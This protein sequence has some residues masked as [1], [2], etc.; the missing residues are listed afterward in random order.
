MMQALFKGGSVDVVVKT[1]Y[2][3]VRGEALDGVASFKGIPY[4]APPIGARRFLAPARPMAWSGVR[5]ALAFGPTAPH[6]TYP[7]QLTHLL[8]EPILPGDD[9][10]TLNVWTPEPRGAGLPV[11]VWIH[12]GAFVNGSSA[13]PTYAGDRFARDGIVCVTINYR[14]G[15]DG[16]LYLEDVP[17]NRGLLDQLAALEWVQ[18]NVAG[19]GGD[20]HNVTIFGESAGAMSVTSLLSMTAARGLFRRA[21]AQSGAGHHALP[22]DTA[23]LVTRE[24]ATRLDVTPTAVGFDTVPLEQLVAAQQQLS[25]D[26][27]TSRDRSVWREIAFD[28][29]PFEPVVDG[30][31][32]AARPIDAIS[33]GAGSDVDVLVGTNLDEYRLFLVPN[34]VVEYVDDS[35]VRDAA[36][37]LGLDTA[38]YEAYRDDEGTPGA[39]LSAILTDWFFWIP[40]LRLA[41]GHRGT[42]YVYEFG[43]RSDLFEGQLGACHALELGFVFDTI[44]A[45]GVGALYEHGA[46]RALAT[47]MHSSW[48]DFARTGNPGW[49]PYEPDTRR[50]RNFDVTTTICDDPR[51]TRRTAW[52]GVR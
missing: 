45:P 48:A 17:S 4:A 3:E 47:S 27:A 15:C 52:D 23:R 1:A 39:T 25:L 34:G 46:P 42:S 14:L 5:D 7:V 51:A 43:W 41:E 28:S 6:G 10:L 33:T 40:A 11:M 35:I 19:F 24:L 22:A 30:D 50:T 13:V 9:C 31:V 16:F 37:G 21:I 38:D 8:P 29:M 26:I 44:D 12:G 20:P 18:E 32:L 36:S 49:D 2:G